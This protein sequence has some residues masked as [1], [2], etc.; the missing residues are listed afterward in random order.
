MDRE[1]EQHIDELITKATKDLKTRICRVAIRH[2]NKLL[3]EQARDLKACSSTASRGRTGT[4]G[5]TGT[6]SKASSSNVENTYT[7]SKNDS[8]SDRYYSD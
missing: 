7:S 2:Q 6:T 3:K 5:R 1:L 4:S 8:D